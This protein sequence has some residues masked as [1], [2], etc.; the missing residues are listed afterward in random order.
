[1]PR[2]KSIADEPTCEGGYRALANAIIMQ[3]AEDYRY[4]L[5]GG[6]I[7]CYCNMGEL[8]QFF[9]SQWF[10][11]LTALDPQALVERLAE[12]CKE[13]ELLISEGRNVISNKVHEKRTYK[14][15]LCG[16]RATVEIKRKR[17]GKPYNGYTLGY[18]EYYCRDCKTFERRDVYISQKS[19]ETAKVKLPIRREHI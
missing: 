19:G 18:E 7:K 17:G 10:G 4:L 5:R 12:E 13:G 6:Y 2:V 14:C 3:A 16:G 15:P 1:M 9:K 8:N 11:A